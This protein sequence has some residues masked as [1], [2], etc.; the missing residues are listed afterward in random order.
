MV[1]EPVTLT[2]NTKHHKH[3]ES[4]GLSGFQWGQVTAIW[5]SREPCHHTLYLV[6]E[7]PNTSQRGDGSH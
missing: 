4:L 5:K 7:N 2:V 6:S 3:K 1:L